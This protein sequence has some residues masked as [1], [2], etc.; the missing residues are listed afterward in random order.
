[1]AARRLPFKVLPLAVTGLERLQP[2]ANASAKAHAPQSASNI[3]SMRLVNNSSIFNDTRM[4]CNIE[5]DSNLTSL[6][7]ANTVLKYFTHP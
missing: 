4:T 1:M 7:F 3:N 6:A 5:E 2:I